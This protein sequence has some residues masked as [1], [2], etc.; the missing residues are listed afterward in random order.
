MGHA[1]LPPDTLEVV[2]RE[3]RVRL[4][5]LGDTAPGLVRAGSGLAAAFGRAVRASGR[6]LV[7][8][9]PARQALPAALPPPSLGPAREVT[10]LAEEVRLLP[11]DPGDRDA[12]ISADEKLITQCGRLLAVW[13]GSPSNGVDATAHMVAYA[14]ARG[15]PVEVVWPADASRAAVAP[16]PGRA[17]A[18]RGANRP[19]ALRGTFPGRTAHRNATVPR[20]ARQEGGLR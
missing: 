4:E 8:L 1:D 20:P 9:L 7:V 5:R 2:E 18:R 11:Y 10:A 13:D 15:V 12:C 6:R 17:G 19:G 16:M 3:L 14:R